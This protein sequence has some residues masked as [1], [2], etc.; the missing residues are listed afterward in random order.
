MKNLG[1]ATCKKNGV[2][3]N[4][5][6]ADFEP[7]LQKKDGT[8]DLLEEASALQQQLVKWRRALHQIPETGIHLPQTMAF[9]KARLDELD[10]AYQ[11]YDEISCIVAEIG[12]GD[13]CFLL[14]SDMDALP[15]KEEAEVSFRAVNGCMHGCGHDMHAAILLGT[16]QLLKAHEEELNGTV[17]LLFQSGEEVFQGGKA[18]IAA[19]VLE[20]PQVEAAFAMHVIA[21]LP[22]GIL[23]T[24]KEPMASVD[25]FKITVI[26]H[27]GHGSMPE[28]CVDP[29]NAAVQVYLAL[30]SLIAREIGG[31]EEAVLTIGQLAAGE[32]AN[33]IPERAVLQGTLRTFKKEVRER[34]VNRI[35]EVADGVAKTYRCQMEYEALSACPG[36]VTDDEVTSQAGKSIQALLPQ[37]QII[38]GAH[39]MG[40]EDF[41]EITDRV[42][43]AYYMIGAGPKDPDKRLGQHNPKIEFNEDVLSIGAAIYA[44]T[45]ADWLKK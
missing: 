11:A 30:Q 8:Q 38:T 7:V 29:I 17:K 3:D 37:A 20:N 42:P 5:D 31:T 36:V 41:A 39:G 21:M 24:G 33:V 4:L 32:T 16:A 9:I 10:I 28:V 13:K 27:G 40:S 12:T 22:A 34:L 19:G 45:A 18:A 23:M 25:G 15:I 1:T 43:G 26:G 6:Q 44:K 2:H 14:R 35:R